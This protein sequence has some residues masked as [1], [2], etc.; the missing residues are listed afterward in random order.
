MPKA[1]GI[2]EIK[3]ELCRFAK[4]AW[5]RRLIAGLGGNVSARVPGEELILITAS[6][7]SLRDTAPRNLIAINLDGELVDKASNLTPSKELGM[8]LAAYRL[9]EEVKAVFHLHPPHATA[10]ATWGS[11]LPLVVDGAK[12]R[13]GYVPCLDY[14]PSGSEMLHNIVQKG[15]G[16]F[17][18][19][20]AYLL[21]NH[22]SITL[23]RSVAE[24][25]YLADLLEDAAKIA[26]LSTLARGGYPEVPR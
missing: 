8:H 20:W 10:F 25:F 1:K 22:G 24:A 3:Q 16:L 26:L 11:P 14:A 5:E 23:G 12:A 18:N 6:G 13:F 7:V 4:L 21:K 2:E 15:I 19:A 17:P 9:R